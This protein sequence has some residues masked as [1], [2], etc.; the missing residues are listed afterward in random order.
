M[1]MAED[2]EI[3]EARLRQIKKKSDARKRQLR[4]M[5][6]KL[7]LYIALADAAISDAARFKLESEVWKSRYEQLKEKMDVN[8]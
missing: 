3:F 7:K 4:A 8:S 1:S 5:N 2:F 6:E